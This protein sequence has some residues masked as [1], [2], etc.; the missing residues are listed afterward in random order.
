MSQNHETVRRWAQEVLNQG[1]LDVVDEIFAPGFT[2]EMPFSEEPLH[3]PEAM[4]ETVAAF[5]AA[6]SDFAIEVEDVLGDGDRIALSYRAHGT[7]DGEFLGSEPTGEYAEWRV[8]HVF[9]IRDGRIAADTT[10]LDRLGLLE[11]LGQLS[12]AG[13]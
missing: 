5:R 10:V 4:R 1:R 8:M 7:N 12:H 11:K 9:T 6:F 13:S 3:G 2:W